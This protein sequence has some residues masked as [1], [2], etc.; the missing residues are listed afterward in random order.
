MGWQKWK[1]TSGVLSDK[2]MPIGLKGKINCMVVRPTTLYETECWPIKKTQV[3]RLIVAEMRMIR[4]TCGYTR[5]DTIR[6]KVITDTVKIAPIEDKMRETRLEL[7]GHVMRR[8]QKGDAR[9]LT[10]LKVDF[11]VVEFTDD[12]AQDRRL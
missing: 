12:M 5:V 10:F 8:S 7:F 9:G 6:N 2:K 4:W 11:K 3:Q 1:Y